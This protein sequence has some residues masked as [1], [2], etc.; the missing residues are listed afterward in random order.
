MEVFHSMCEELQLGL[1]S[2]VD[3]VAQWL[4]DV[5]DVLYMRGF[6]GLRD[7]VFTQPGWLVDL[8]KAVICHDH[9]SS[10]RRP[11]AYYHSSSWLTLT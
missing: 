11:S 3:G 4:E 6:N 7:Y 2:Q 5:G 1:D 10:A 8:L 9:D